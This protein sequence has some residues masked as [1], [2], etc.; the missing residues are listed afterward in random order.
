MPAA[1]MIPAWR[2]PLP[3]IFRKRRAWA[4]KSR[5]PHTTEP[6]GAESPFDTQNVTES[7]WRVKSE[8]GRFSAIAAL[9]SRAP[10]RCTG[11][12]AACATLA[13]A[14][15]SSGVMQVPPW[16]LCVFSRQTRPVWGR[17]MFAGR[18]ASRTCSGV[19]KPRA[20]FIARVWTLASRALPATSELKMWQSASSTISWPGWVCAHTETRLPWVPDVTKTAAS[21]AMRSAAIASRRLTVGSSS[22]TSSPTSA[23]AIASRIAGVGRVIVSERKSMMGCIGVLPLGAPEA[24]RRATAELRVAVFGL[25][26]AKER[27][28]F[29]RPAFFE[30]HLGEQDH[31]FGHDERA[32]VLLQDLLEALAGRDGVA[33]LV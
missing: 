8:A 22:Q 5:E 9:K 3:N 16:P 10:S 26:A 7:T 12:F 27:H 33:L 11:T 24:R 31:R 25:E 28:R 30:V 13:T 1:A 20:V 21:L 29:F 32:A 15:V 18:S 6:T 17:W 14:A 2:S 19:R 4:I 23:R